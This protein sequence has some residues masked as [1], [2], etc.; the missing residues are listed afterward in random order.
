MSYDSESDLKYIDSTDDIPVSGP[1]P[2]DKS[3]KLDAAE[4]GEAR[5][6]ADVNDGATID[7][8]TVL[9]REA[10]AA[11]ASYRLFY[12]GESPT[13]ALSGDLVDGSSNDIMELAREHK[14]NYDSTIASIVDSEADRDNDD[15][16]DFVVFDV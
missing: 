11:F 8:A 9:I 16:G 10:A 12:G 13:S 4:V 7:G 2:F 1:D 15:A 5:V 3:E 14:A 6:E